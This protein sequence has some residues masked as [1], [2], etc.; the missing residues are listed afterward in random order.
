M[1]S[2]KKAIIHKIS[3]SKSY[4]VYKLLTFS[5]FSIN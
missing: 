4:F 5:V 1:I 2:K 3:L